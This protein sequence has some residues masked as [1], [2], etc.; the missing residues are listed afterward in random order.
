[1][2]ALSEYTSETIDLAPVGT[3][4]SYVHIEREVHKGLIGS[5]T[6][7]N[8]WRSADDA[9]GVSEFFAAGIH[10]LNTARGAANRAWCRAMHS[11][12]LPVRL[13]AQPF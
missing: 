2:S 9:N 3:T 1:M 11:A 10:D 13:T 12:N 7:Y 5:R 6:R 8:V 4:K